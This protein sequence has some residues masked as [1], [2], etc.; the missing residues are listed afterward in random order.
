[1]KIK[2]LLTM[3]ALS[4]LMSCQAQTDFKSVDIK[5]FKIEFYT[6]EDF[7]RF[8]REPYET[9]RLQELNFVK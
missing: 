9:I 5:E 7:K 8:L 6:A 3:L 4:I 2:Y 1:M